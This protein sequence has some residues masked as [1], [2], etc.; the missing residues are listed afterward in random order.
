MLGAEGGDR[1]GV[2]GAEG[3]VG[4]GGG[5]GGDL[6]EG[7]GEGGVGVGAGAHHHAAPLEP[8][9]RVAPRE[10]RHEAGHRQRGFPRAAHALEHER[11]LGLELAG[12]A[13]GVLVAAEEHALRGGAEGAEPE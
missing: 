5:E 10:L 2:L 9:G 1:G 7:A 13:R 8:A 6:V 4:A 12:E 11:G 3:R